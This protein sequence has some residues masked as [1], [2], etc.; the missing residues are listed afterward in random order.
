MGERERKLNEINER[1]EDESKKYPGNQADR[2]MMGG[3]R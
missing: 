1:L 2:G 3:R